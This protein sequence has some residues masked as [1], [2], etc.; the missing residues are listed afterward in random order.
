MWQGLVAAVR[1]RCGIDWLERAITA[2][3]AVFPNV[4]KIE[5]WQDCGLLVPHVQAIA[6]RLEVN[7]VDVPEVG[8]VLSQAE[9]Y[10]WLS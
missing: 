10:L 6:N 5:N 2:L 4:S 3:N 8:L 7:P 1:H 9:Y